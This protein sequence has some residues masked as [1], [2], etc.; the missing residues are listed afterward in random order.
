MG[1][2]GGAAKLNQTTF[3]SME[4]DVV[5][6]VSFTGTMAVVFST[7]GSSGT[8]VEGSGGTGGGW[9]VPKFGVL[10]FEFESRFLNKSS[11]PD[12]RWLFGFSFSGFNSSADLTDSLQLS[13]SFLVGFFSSFALWDWECWDTLIE[14]PSRPHSNIMY[15]MGTSFWESWFAFGQHYVK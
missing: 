13:L 12:V 5:L 2:R 9:A 4:Q 15:P 14:M 8:G 11:M 10:G 3:K 1:V 7:G 6:P